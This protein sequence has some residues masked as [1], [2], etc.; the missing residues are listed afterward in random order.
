MAKFGKSGPRPDRAVVVATQVIE[1][2]LNLDFDLVISDIA[3][4]SLLIQRLGRCM[5]FSVDENGRPIRRPL[6]S[7]GHPTLVVLDPVNLDSDVPTPPEWDSVYPS[8]E[9]AAT[10][11][12][13]V[14]RPPELAVPGDVDGAVQQVHDAQASGVPAKL[15]A[16]W[17]E[18]YGEKRAQ[19]QLARMAAIEPAETIT[20]LSRLTDPEVSDLDV[21]TRL[22]VDTARLVPRYASADGQHWLDAEHNVK[23]PS[24]RP[25][26]TEVEQFIN[27]S[28]TC[29]RAWA[30]A[31]G[32]QTNPKWSRTPM[33][34]DAFILPAPEYG[35]L[36]VDERLGL[37]RRKKGTP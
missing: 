5:R 36:V 4:I 27:A 16:L 10:H 14:E 2:S 19:A 1:Q 21:S 31:E 11:Q 33:L 29:P 13:L 25:G 35:R 9:V 24:A 15:R 12:V 26:E 30:E 23:W 7:Q 32:L 17:D 8:F 18:Q 37:V 3:P 28:I 22:G 20:D 34:R 6:W